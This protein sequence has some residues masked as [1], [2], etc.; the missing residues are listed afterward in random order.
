MVLRNER[1]RRRMQM[2]TNKQVS[3][4]YAHAVKSRFIQYITDA[5]S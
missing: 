2:M 4:E 3:G 1:R 5:A